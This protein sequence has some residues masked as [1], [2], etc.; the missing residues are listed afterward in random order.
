MLQIRHLGPGPF[1]ILSS[2]PS[3]LLQFRHL[4][5]DHIAMSPSGSCPY[6][7]FLSGPL[8]LVQVHHLNPDPI[9]ILFY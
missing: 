9:A 7:N 3:A 8:S 4:D 2:E 5:T 1:A 6:F